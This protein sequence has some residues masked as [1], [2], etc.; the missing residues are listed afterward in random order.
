MAEFDAATVEK[1]DTILPSFA[2]KTNPIDLT[3]PGQHRADLLKDACEAV[4]AD[5]RTEAVIVQFAC[6]GRRHLMENAEVFKALA[7]EVPVFLSFIGRTRRAASCARISAMRA[8]CC[9]P[10]PSA[11]MKALS[12]LY[13]RR[14]AMRLP[15]LRAAR[16]AAAAA[17]RRA[18]GPT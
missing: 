4:A 11:A 17:R 1:L 13:R 3:G 6:T 5:R 16:A 10:I 2:R 9:A 14:D 7:R 12:L 15:A 8:C 18:T